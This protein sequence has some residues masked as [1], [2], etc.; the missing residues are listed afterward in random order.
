[1]RTIRLANGEELNITAD[2]IQT[3]GDTLF[4]SLIPGDRTLTDY[5]DI[6]KQSANTEKITVVDYLG[7]DFLTHSGYTELQRIEKQYDAVV[8]YTVKDD[9]NKAL[10]RG[11]AVHIYLK[12]PATEESE[13]VKAAKILL[14]EA[15]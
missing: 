5:E 13:Y 7:E 11:V 3:S 14:G 6:F 12:R 15:E 1:M 9:G 8:D 4:L 10:L 2:G